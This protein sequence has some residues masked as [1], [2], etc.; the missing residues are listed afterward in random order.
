MYQQLRTL[1]LAL[2]LTLLPITLLQAQPHGRP[3]GQPGG[4]GAILTGRILD[5]DLNK[6]I[7]YATFVLFEASDSTQVTGTITDEDGDFRLPGV[8]PGRYYA[9]VSFLG[10]VPKIVPNIQ[11]KPGSGP[12]N[13]GEIALPQASLEMESVNYVVQRSP[14]EYQIDKKVVHVEKQATSASGTAVDILENVPSVQVDIEGN[15]E[16][17]GSTNFKVLIDGR[18]TILDAS[19]A[20]QQ[21][22]AGSIK[23]IEIITNPSAKYDPE[24]TAGL[25]N[26]VLKKERRNGDSGMAT[27]DLGTPGRY[28]ANLLYQHKYDGMNI[29]LGGDYN[30]RTMPGTRDSYTRTT[31]PNGISTITRAHGDMDREHNSWG[32]RGSI[33]KDLTDIDWISLGARYGGH[34]GGHSGD[35]DYSEEVDTSSTVNRYTSTSDRDRSE[36]FIEVH[37]DYRHQFNKDGHELTA[38]VQ[39]SYEDGDENTTDRLLEPD[40][41]VSS[42]RKSVEKGPGSEVE[43]RLEYVYPMTEKRRFESGYRLDRNA[44]NEDNQLWEYDTTLGGFVFEPQYSHST[45]YTRTIHALYALYAD[46]WGP[47][48]AQLGLRGEYTDRLIKLTDTGQRFTIDR[49]D[50]FPTLHT[51]YEWKKDYQAMASYSRRI[52]RPHSWSLEPFKTWIDAYNVRQGNPDLKPEYID[53]YELG[54]QLPLGP[55]H[56]STEVY[57]RVTH[58]LFEYTSEA[59]AP[60]VT[61]RS[62]KNVGTGYALGT[63]IMFTGDLMPWLN[64]NLMGNLFNNRIE[65]NTGRSNED[66]SWSSRLALTFKVSP[67]LKIQTNGIYN[68]PVVSSQG[69]RNAF[70]MVNGAVETNFLNKS[71]TAILQVRDIFDTA[72]YSRITE[73]PNLYSEATFDRT[74][75]FI[76]LTLR[77]NIN[78][79]R[80]RRRNGNGPSGGDMGGEG[81]MM[82]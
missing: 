34:S 49:T 8:K 32:L 79:F 57:Y 23:D 51:S 33:D 61:L 63:E 5:G 29:I 35:T 55:F 6:P 44:S 69:R 3:G 46:A 77:Y 7:Q 60:G 14:V 62:P 43:A 4:P 71:L 82:E 17:R 48:G 36:D 10:Y 22:P 76:G 72:N 78:N 16:L 81:D 80:E 65:V 18:P 1:S 20:L 19:D 25:I 59:Y 58:N 38:R 68:S 54:Y 74:G 12:V 50:L 67:R 64:M 53:S 47:F 37:S 56:H 13:V 66:F 75:P 42:G 21:I 11:V 73:G 40:G 31:D 26:I 27:V 52:D 41:T 45:D 2:L 9:K 28:G 24:G 30:I 15:V 39:Y 70:S